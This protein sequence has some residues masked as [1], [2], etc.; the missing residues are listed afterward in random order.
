MY[1]INFHERLKNLRLQSGLT[2]D[3]LA[4]KLHACGCAATGKFAI[5]RYEN[6]QRLPDVR[7]LAVIAGFFNVSVDYMLRI[8][9]KKR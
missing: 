6:N 8:E 9:E 3:E 2:Q 1:N 4:K 5:S 7:S